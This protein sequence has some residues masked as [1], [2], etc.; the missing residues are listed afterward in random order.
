[1]QKALVTGGTGFTGQALCAR[2]LRDGWSVSSFVRASSRVES[3]RRMGVECLEVDIGD[4]EQ[5][6]RA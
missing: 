5:V 4:P 3:L 6:M 2:L 1:M